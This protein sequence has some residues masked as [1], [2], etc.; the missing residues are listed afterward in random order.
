MEI[1][2]FFLLI[3][4][5]KQ[6]QLLYLLLRTITISVPLLDFSQAIY[7]CYNVGL[8]T[9][10]SNKLPLILCSPKCSNSN[11]EVENAA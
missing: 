8:K 9:E 5:L 4:F 6:A 1:S 10:E 11:T 7:C 2:F 3:I